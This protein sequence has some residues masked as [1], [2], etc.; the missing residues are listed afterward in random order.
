M[1]QYKDTQ[2]K[3]LME[4]SINMNLH[5]GDNLLTIH[6]AQLVYLNC[7]DLCS[8]SLHQMASYWLYQKFAKTDRD[9]QNIKIVAVP[10]LCNASV[11]LKLSWNVCLIRIYLVCTLKDTKV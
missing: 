3:V 1:Y 10:F 6:T 11:Q 5:I 4:F 8:D 9:H 2:G 7:Q